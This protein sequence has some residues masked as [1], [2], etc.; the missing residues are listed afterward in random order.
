M[1]DYGHMPRTVTLYFKVAERDVTLMLREAGVI[2]DGR[3][4]YED[5][6]DIMAGQIGQ[7]QKRVS[8][9]QATEAEVTNGLKAGENCSSQ[10]GALTQ[11]EQ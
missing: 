3:I 4:Y 7:Q 2:V 11:D 1:K 9:L 6:L 5:F 10:N 8:M